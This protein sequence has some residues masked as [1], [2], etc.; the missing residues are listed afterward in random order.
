M[1]ELSKEP[2][3]DSILHLGTILEI[4]Q[5]KPVPRLSSKGCTFQEC[6]QVQYLSRPHMERYR[7]PAYESDFSLPKIISLFATMRHG[8]FKLTAFSYMRFQ[9]TGGGV[10]EV[11]P[12]L[13]ETDF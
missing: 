1:C 7:N 12:V 6:W 8:S 4:Q 5:F 11:N 13:K 3:K 9:T 2:C 10:M